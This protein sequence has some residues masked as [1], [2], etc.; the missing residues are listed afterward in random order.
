MDDERTDGEAALDDD[1]L[2]ERLEQ[3]LMSH[4]VYVTDLETEAGTLRVDY[5]TATPGTGVPHREVGRVLNRLLALQEDGWTP[6]D[7]RGTVADIDGDRR[8]TWRADEEWL[9]AHAR[10]D[11]S[12]VDLSQRVLDTIEET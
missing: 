5:E 11:L 1:D 6:T 9:A 8:G 10:G 2:R 3:R 4:G 7:V 12:D